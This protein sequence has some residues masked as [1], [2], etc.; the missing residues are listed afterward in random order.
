MG[1]LIGIKKDEHID[2]KIHEE[3]KKNEHIDK[4][5]QREKE[6]YEKLMQ[7]EMKLHKNNYQEYENKHKEEADEY[8]N[9]P[10]IL[11]TNGRNIKLIPWLK[12]EMERSQLSRDI[13]NLENNRTQR[14]EALLNKLYITKNDLYHNIIKFCQTY[15]KYNVV[16]F[17]NTCKTGDIMSFIKHKKITIKIHIDLLCNICM[18]YRF[19]GYFIDKD[20]DNIYC[21]D[22]TDEFVMIN[23]IILCENISDIIIYYNGRPGLVYDIYND[24]IIFNRQRD[25]DL[26]LKID[27][28]IY[29]MKV[30]GTLIK[31]KVKFV[32]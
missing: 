22:N 24:E 28:F 13:K 31:M 32:N 27:H 9:S 26:L 18:T 23:K 4:E 12:N 2:K 25:N 5:I 1:N 8:D 17:K 6:L 3:I 11:T 10:M 7:D 15:E 30:D 19:L 21:Y 29:K 14:K 16:P 20:T